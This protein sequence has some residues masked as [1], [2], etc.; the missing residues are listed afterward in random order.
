MP[1][2]PLCPVPLT[3]ACRRTPFTP[4][5]GAAAPEAGGELGEPLAAG[6]LGHTP[7]GAELDGELEDLL[8][9][10]TELPAAFL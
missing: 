3:T 2:Y 5:R 7:G 1:T 4:Y 9:P 8:S 6:Q 10:P